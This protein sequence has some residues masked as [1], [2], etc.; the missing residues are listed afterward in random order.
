MVCGVD[1]E[2][3]GKLTDAAWRRP[4]P[5]GADEDD[6]GGHVDLAAEEAYRRWR[7]SFPATV[8]IA[9][10]AQSEAHWLGKLGGEA[11]W[12]PEIVGRVESSAAGTPLLANFVGKLAVN[13]E[14]VQQPTDTAREIVIHG[15]VLRGFE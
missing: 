8:A 11:T 1:A 9:T 3:L 6:D 4:L 14:K 13:F 10:E 5:H 15:Q 12:S 7:R 2:A